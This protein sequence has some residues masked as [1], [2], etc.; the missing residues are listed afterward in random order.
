MNKRS[1][2]RF[3]R[4]IFGTPNAVIIGGTVILSAIFLRG[5]KSAFPFVVM[6][7]ILLVFSI[8]Y[9]LIFKK[10][11]EAIDESSFDLKE[12]NKVR[13]NLTPVIK[14]IINVL[15]NLKQ[16]SQDNSKFMIIS[17]F[18]DEIVDFEETIP[19]IV[20]S[21]RKGAEFLHAR[22]G[23][24]NSEVKSLQ[25]KLR[26]ATGDN[27][28]AMYQKALDEKQQTLNEML[29][30]RSNLDECESKLHFILS[31]LQR[32]ETIIESSE[33]QEKMSEEETQDLNQNVEA[34][35]ESIRDISKL[36]EL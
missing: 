6:G 19:Q 26:N 30:I 27:A 14:N 8:L 36:M 2:N 18:M 32:I 1:I 16:K 20:R 3:S 33:L 4:A 31:A 10:N 5:G 12:L 17:R 7:A 35:S 24:I 28:K 34:F 15:N 29:G 13:D 22:D 23:R 25:D 9:G 21:Y 11:A